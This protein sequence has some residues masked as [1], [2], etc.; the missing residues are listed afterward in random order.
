MP[1]YRLREDEPIATLGELKARPT[2][3]KRRRFRHAPPLR[4]LRWAK[5]P[6]KRAA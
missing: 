5:P 1:L 4:P 6:T 3:F 2:A